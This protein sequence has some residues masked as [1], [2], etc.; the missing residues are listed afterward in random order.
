MEM[1]CREGD[2]KKT[3][4]LKQFCKLTGLGIKAC[5]HKGIKQILVRKWRDMG[6][7]R[8]RGETRRYKRIVI[9]GKKKGSVV[10]SKCRN[11]F[12][13]VKEGIVRGK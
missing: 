5:K 13:G 9:I 11:H 1:P 4:E 2:M 12:K 7:E 6:R 8:D 10:K 3:C